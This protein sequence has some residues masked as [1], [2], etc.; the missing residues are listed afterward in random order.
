MTDEERAKLIKKLD[1]EMAEYLDTME[2][3]AQTGPGYQEGW[4]EDNWEKEMESHP[5]FAS[6]QALL[7]DAAKGQLS[8]LM[9][10]LQLLKYSPDENSKEDLAKNYKEDGNFQFK[11]KKYRLAIAA[12]TEGIRCKG[13]DNLVNVQLITNR[14]ASQ[15][16]LGNF[17]SSFNDSMLAVKLKPDHFKAL[18][19]GALCCFE[20]KRYSDCVTWCD[21][22]LKVETEDK[23]LIQLKDKAKSELK[24]AERNSRREA[25]RKKKKL[26]D[27]IK[28]VKTLQDRKVQLQDLNLE[29]INVDNEDHLEAVFEKLTPILPAATKKRVH[30]NEN[31]II[32]P[33]LFMYPEYGETDLIEEF[34][35]SGQTF[36]DHIQ[37]MFGHGIE[38]PNWDISNK[39]HPERLKVYF[40]DRVTNPDKVALVALPDNNCT[41]SEALSDPRYQ[42]VNGLPTFIVLVDKSHYETFMMKSYENP[43]LKS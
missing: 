28:L 41:L 16:H 12:Y 14:A 4:S 33:V 34:E 42:V 36:E 24:E 5:F 38:R 9:E 29:K 35:E 8:P 23:D 3:K 39:Y 7:E 31:T 18:K 20:L 32:W 37:A 22:A 19:R 2:S 25:A 26:K 27:H 43:S 1:D 21:K 11:L 6:N 10:G 15:F 30:L 40:E 13:E 17:R